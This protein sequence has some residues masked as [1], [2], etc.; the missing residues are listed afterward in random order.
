MKKRKIVSPM[1]R[2]RPIKCLY[3]DQDERCPVWGTA[4]SPDYLK[5]C[6]Q[7]FERETQRNPLWRLFA[8]WKQD[9]S[10]RFGPGA[11]FNQFFTSL[12]QKNI[13][14]GGSKNILWAQWNAQNKAFQTYYLFL[15]RDLRAVVASRIRNHQDS[16]TSACQRIF[17]NWQ[18]IAQ[19]RQTLPATQYH[20]VRYETLVTRP[21]FVC[22]DICDF[23][24]VPF[25]PHML[26][27]YMFPQHVF[28]GNLASV[29]ANRVNNDRNIDDLI[30]DYQPPES[31]TQS[32][33]YVEQKPGFRLD[34]RWQ[35]ELTAEQLNEFDNIAGRIN[36]HLGY[37]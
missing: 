34:T 32:D 28:G 7:R 26:E 17:N 4:V 37:G 14:V 24:K 11:L 20:T 33:Y 3:C 31:Y 18:H 22:Q 12:P 27:Y 16:I 10:K 21:K 6:F 9:R 35:R 23:L 13:I 29:L 36:R 2:G 25:E 5:A 19:F 15:E 1:R 8:R 30:A